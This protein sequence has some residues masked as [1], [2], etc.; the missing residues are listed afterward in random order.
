MLAHRAALPLRRLARDALIAT[1]STLPS[2]LRRSLAWDQ[3]SKLAAHK[4]FAI[5]TGMPIYFCNPGSPWQHGSNENTNSL[6]RQYFPKRTD[7]AGHTRQAPTT[8]PPNSTRDH[9]KRSAG[10]LQP[11]ASLSFSPKPVDQLVLQR[12]LEFAIARRCRS[13]GY[14][15]QSPFFERRVVTK[16]PMIDALPVPKTPRPWVGAP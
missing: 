4:A 6:L 9:A 11:S 2:H 13:R 3:G 10:N 14:A 5:A 1:A 12:P 16:A 7:L 8:P 15:G